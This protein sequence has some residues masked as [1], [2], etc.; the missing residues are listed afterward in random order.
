MIIVL[1]DHIDVIFPKEGTDRHVLTSFMEFLNYN[2]ASLFVVSL[3]QD[4]FNL[5][6]IG[7]NNSQM[8]TSSYPDEIHGT[9]RNSFD[10]SDITLDD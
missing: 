1:L 9:V 3:I 4:R 10:V 7:N 6:L 5:T 2:R 8:A